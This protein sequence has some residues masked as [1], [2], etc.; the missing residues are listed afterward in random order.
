MLPPF[1]GAFETEEEVR[2]QRTNEQPNQTDYR[3]IQRL[4]LQTHA[5]TSRSPCLNLNGCIDNLVYKS[6]IEG[7]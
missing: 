7:I 5:R 1:H 4:R 6:V 2:I 3:S